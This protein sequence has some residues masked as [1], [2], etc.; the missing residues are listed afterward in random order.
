V[1][2]DGCPYTF[3]ELANKVLP[4]ILEK[5]RVS[6]KSARPAALFCDPRKK[7]KVLRKELGLPDNPGGLYVFLKDSIPFYVGIT[8]KLLSRLRS[9]LTGKKHFA[10]TLAFKMAHA[11][12]A[13]N[14][15]EK[16]SRDKLMRKR[17]FKNLFKSAKN[18]LVGSQ[19]AFVV[20][21]DP[22]T[23]YLLEVFLA[24]AFDTKEWNTFRT[25]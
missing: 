12:W 15:G 17:E 3:E 11:V 16:L 13:K 24:M 10:A 2:I 1:A 6:C 5:L 7:P 18:D 22:V 23:L 20:V 19:I 25:H 21:E 8:R 4:G 9:H 14:K